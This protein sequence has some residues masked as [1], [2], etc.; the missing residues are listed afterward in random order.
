MDMSTIDL[1]GAISLISACLFIIIIVFFQG[2]AKGGMSQSITGQS[3]DNYYQRNMGRSK[4]MKLKKFTVIAAAIYFLGAIAVNMIA[5]H[6]PN[7]NAPSPS[8]AIDM[9]D[10][11]WE[12]I[13]AGMGDDDFDFGDDD[14]DHGDE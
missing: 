6:F 3:S 14:H 7:D 9:E 12:S 5:V 8:P 1:V 2:S 11:D 4:E 13:L 10:F